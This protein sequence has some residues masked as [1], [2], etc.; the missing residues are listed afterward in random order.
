MLYLIKKNAE[1]A[2]ISNAK[3]LILRRSVIVKW[4]KNV[5]IKSIRILASLKN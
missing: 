1:I 2:Q 4:T 3:D 5:T